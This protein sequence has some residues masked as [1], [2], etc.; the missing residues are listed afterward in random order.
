MT[1]D[2]ILDQD[3]LTD[4]KL[5]MQKQAKE[6]VQTERWKP[7]EGKGQP[8]TGGWGRGGDGEKCQNAQ[9]RQ[10][11]PAQLQTQPV[12]GRE[13]RGGG[14][15]VGPPTQGHVKRDQPFPTH[16]LIHLI[17]SVMMPPRIYLVNKYL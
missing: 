8:E 6:E 17:I 16:L 2:N 7:A 15:E 12:W 3:V 13:T 5:L 9:E 11:L 14:G 10:E 1:K 4:G